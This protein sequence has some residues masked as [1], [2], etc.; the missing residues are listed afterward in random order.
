M[1]SGI[2][3][4]VY[5]IK[6]FWTARSLKMALRGCTKTMVWNYKSTLREVQKRVIH[7]TFIFLYLLYG[8]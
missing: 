7:F 4:N 3:C 6:Q 8:T 2:F 5:D 1:I